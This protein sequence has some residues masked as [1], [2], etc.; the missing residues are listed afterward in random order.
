M[1]VVAAVRGTGV[2]NSLKVCRVFFLYRFGLE[3]RTQWFCSLSQARVGSPNYYSR[4]HHTFS[5]A[6]SP[7]AVV[8]VNLL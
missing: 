5:H 6:P 3:R 8:D 7:Y 1:M 2:M 4:R